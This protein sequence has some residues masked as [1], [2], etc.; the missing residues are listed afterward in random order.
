MDER[1]LL[2]LLREAAADGRIKVALDYRRLGHTDSPIA[3]Q[4]DSNRWLYGIAGATLGVGFAVGW[5]PAAVPLG[6][7]VAL[8]FAL[9]RSWVRRR[10]H[11][12][13]FGKTLMDLSAFKQL[14][15]IRG[16]TLTDAGD[17]AACASPDGD[18]RRFVLDRLAPLSGA[19]GG[20]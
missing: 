12:R 3:V 11:R 20:P 9:G 7:G 13:F 17:G 5:L 4:A 6:L 14:W 19:G 10:M 16:V 15:H 18:W 8:Y 1:V 2:R